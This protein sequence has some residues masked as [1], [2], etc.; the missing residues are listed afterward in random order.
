M[1]RP[2][3]KELTARELE[4]MQSFWSDGP[5]TAAEVRDRLATSGLDRAYTTIANLVR[6]LHSK[7]LLEQINEERPFC[8]QAVR[9]F[10]EVSHNLVSDLLERVFGGSRDQ[11]FRS[12]LEQRK[13]TAKERA[14]L[15][16]VLQDHH[17]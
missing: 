6:V 5:G 14:V 10:E 1:A 2:P 7:G 17:R 12:L 11:L 16:R 15:E 13:L 9:S 8:Y 3:A 4:V